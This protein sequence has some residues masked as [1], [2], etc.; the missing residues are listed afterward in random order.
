[1]KD[2]TLA[3]SVFPWFTVLMIQ[4]T[5]RDLEEARDKVLSAQR[6]IGGYR[7]QGEKIAEKAIQ[8]VEVL[9]G[10]AASGVVTGRFGAPHLKLG[11]QNL[12]LDLAGGVVLHGLAFFGMFGKYGDHVHNFSDGVM[13]QF[14][15]RWG[16][17]YGTHLREK[18]GLPRIAGSG[19][20]TRQFPQQAQGH[21]YGRGQHPA[22]PQRPLTEAELAG[23]ASRMR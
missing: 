3:P 14:F 9:A 18:A 21:A 13:A 6:I 17:G 20:T 2:E 11:S 16:V 4:L 12:P 15:A 8:S 22:P 5:R 23:L 1:M 7:S 10:A 19:N